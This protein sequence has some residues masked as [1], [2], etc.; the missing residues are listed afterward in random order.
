MR[1]DRCRADVAWFENAVITREEV[2]DS[3]GGGGGGGRAGAD[4]EE[5]A[6]LSLFARLMRLE[7]VDHS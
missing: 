3:S 6:H 2:G 7:Q 5:V 4:E 1:F